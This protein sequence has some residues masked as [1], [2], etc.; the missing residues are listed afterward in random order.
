VRSEK[1]PNG[2]FTL[3]DG[4]N[5]MTDFEQTSDGRIVAVSLSLKKGVK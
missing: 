3:K 1:E 5:N 2:K 4:K